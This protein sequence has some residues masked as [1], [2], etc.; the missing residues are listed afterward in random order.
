MANLERTIEEKYDRV[1]DAYD[2]RWGSY[3]DA[4]LGYFT[5]TLRLRGDEHLL[6]VSC[7][8]GEL[9]RRLCA[10]HPDLRITGLDLS[11]EMLEQARQKVNGEPQVTFR[12]GRADDLPF[13]DETFDVVTSTSAFHYYHRPRQVLREFGRV[14]R[15]GGSL[16]MI[17][18]NAD[19]WL[20][21]L[22]DPMLRGFDATYHG[23][24]APQEARRLLEEASFQGVGVTDAQVGWM[25]GV[26]MAMGRRAGSM[27]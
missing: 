27:E 4:T 13:D 18:W 23:C 19:H 22:L 11:N 5:D 6:D 10:R 1:A 12:Q 24:Y 3:V 14:L 2:R 8:T 15:P 26:W 21:T 9:I 7:G 17:D 25:W 20:W 16:A